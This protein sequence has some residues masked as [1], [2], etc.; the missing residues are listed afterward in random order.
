ME[1]TS[2]I[3]KIMSAVGCCDI[4]LHIIS[5]ML[6]I[7]CSGWIQWLWA[8][9]MLQVGLNINCGYYSNGYSNWLCQ[10]KHVAP[11]HS[12]ATWTPIAHPQRTTIASQ[13]ASLVSLLPD[14]WMSGDRNTTIVREGVEITVCSKHEH[15]RCDMCK[16]DFIDL[17]DDYRKA[18]LASKTRCDRP[19]C[20]SRDTKSLKCGRCLS[21][22]Y[23]SAECQRLHWNAQHKKD[24]KRTE[25]VSIGTTGGNTIH[26]YPVKSKIKCPD[27]SGNNRPL[28]GR[29]ISYNPGTGPYSDGVQHYIPNSEGCLP[30]YTIKFKGDAGC[31][32][33]PCEDV[34]SEWELLD[35]KLVD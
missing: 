3:V 22:R 34:H 1:S 5:V 25:H 27:R 30:S 2:V 9:V 15:E 12:T 23:C 17:N 6:F 19:E 28:F 35:S 31:E 21:V 33:V 11:S 14:D 24:C 32:K 7:G 26:L 20:N 10:H 4:V 18:A 16:L 13:P 8:C 29:I